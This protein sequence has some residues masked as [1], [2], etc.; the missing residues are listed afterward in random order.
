[1]PSPLDFQVERHEGPEPRVLTED[2]Q[3]I[4]KQVTK[5]GEDDGAAVTLIAE[6]AKV[7]TRT[8]YRVLQNKRDDEEEPSISL[9]LAD[10]LCLAAGQHV[11]I[12]RLRWPDGRITPYH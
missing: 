3:A 11:A 1:M 6:R 8:V 10:R 4:L 12:C 2:V 5:P 9:D 7:S